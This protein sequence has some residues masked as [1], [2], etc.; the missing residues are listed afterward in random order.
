MITKNFTIPSTAKSLIEDDTLY[1]T[2]IA[3][4]G[5]EDLVGDVVT[6]DALK[7]ICDQIP[8]HNLH[9]DHDSDI[10]AG[11]LGPMVDGW[12]ESDGVH[13]KARIVNEQR[14]FIESYISQ[15]VHLGASISGVCNYADGSDSDIVDWS[16]TEISL[17]AIPCD[18]G[19]MASVEIAKSFSDAVRG[20]KEFKNIE[21]ETMADEITLE[22]IKT[23]IE[24]MINA[25][26]NEKQEDLIEAV[27]D[28]VKTENE[29]VISEMKERIETLE[30]Q[31][32]EAGN[33]TSTEDDGENATPGAEGEGE[34][35]GKAAEDEE[36]EEE[37]T[38][39]EEDE[40]E[41]DKKSL[42][43]FIQETIQ[44]EIRKAFTP[45]DP[46]FQYKK[47]IESEESKKSFT[48]AE[49]AELLT[50]TE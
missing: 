46:S 1:I 16:L 50:R 11:L 44:S 13:F 32:A 36:E 35:A 15:G 25:A 12:V 18:Q 2:G 29:A 7:Q 39:D 4:T 40:E 31:I 14:D 43:S 22:E 47:S 20:I 28:E 5:L 45:A 33:E 42:K 41:D 26:F 48:P 17:T 19:T 30:A 8:R 37:E 34:G 49:L 10:R 6:Q 9:L 24:E 38:Q 27:R 21:G 23:L 3:N